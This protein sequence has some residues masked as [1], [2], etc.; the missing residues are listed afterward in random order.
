MELLAGV[1]SSI[2]SGCP[3]NGP[4]SQPHSEAREAPLG[5]SEAELIL[6]AAPAL[7]P[8]WSRGKGIRWLPTPEAPASGRM[9]LLTNGAL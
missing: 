2:L 8:L 9:L 4:P 3:A 6:P 7:A 1:A 5:L